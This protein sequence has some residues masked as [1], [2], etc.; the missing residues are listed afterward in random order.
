MSVYS[1]QFLAVSLASSSGSPYESAEVPVNYVWV[2]RA[3]SFGGRLPPDDE[4]YLFVVDPDGVEYLIAHYT[5]AG[6]SGAPAIEFITGRL[7]LN[8]GWKIR[9]QAITGE[10]DFIISGYQLSNF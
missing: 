7:V 2:L 10:T 9:L 4:C 1:S 6:G 8:P 3:G 5:D